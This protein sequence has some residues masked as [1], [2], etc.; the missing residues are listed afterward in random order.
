MG[1]QRQ[2]RVLGLRQPCDAAMIASW[3]AAAARTGSYIMH[4]ASPHP[5]MAAERRP[6]VEER[7][8]WPLSTITWR[9]PGWRGGLGTR[10]RPPLATKL[11]A[12]RRR[13]RSP[14]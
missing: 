14:A 4:T 2:P 6:G 8:A 12:P 13:Q 9:L 5:N 10:R 3:G 7:P 1:E 11:N